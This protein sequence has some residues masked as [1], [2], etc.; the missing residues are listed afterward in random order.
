MSR[1]EQGEQSLSLFHRV[2]FTCIE[3]EMKTPSVSLGNREA[4][5][6]CLDD[7]RRLKE[8]SFSTEEDLRNSTGRRRRRRN[9]V[10]IITRRNDEGTESSGGGGSEGGEEH[11]VMGNVL[12]SG[13][14]PA[15][16][17]QHHHRPQETDAVRAS[18]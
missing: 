17:E 9:E 2:P 3:R 5:A 18:E 16:G 7:R 10:T 8:C 11:F 15:A 14:Y 1:P 13:H 12:Q 6:G 4:A